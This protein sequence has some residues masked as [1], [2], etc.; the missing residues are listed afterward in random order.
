M[1][2][3]RHLATP[4]SEY[5]AL[6]AQ[7]PTLPPVRDV[8]VLRNMTKDIVVP[9]LNRIRGA[10]LPAETKY[11]VTDYEIAVDG[12]TISVRCTTPTK[13][14]VFPL[15]VWVHGGGFVTGTLEPD[16]Y[17]LRAL[18]VELGI[19]TVNV[20]YR[21]APE[22]RFPTPLN[23]CYA[24]LKWAADNAA[25][26]SASVTKGFI[27]GGQS[28]GGNLVAALAYRAREDPF[29]QGRALTGHLLQY[30]QVIHP[31]AVPARYKSELLSMEE[32]KDAPVLKRDDLLFFAQAYQAEPYN[33]ECSP[34]LYPS[35]AGL[36]PLYMQ[37]CGWD[38][39]RD[40]CLLYEK[41]L[42]EAGADTK[43]D[44]Y[45]G[46]PHIFAAMHPTLSQAVKHDRDMR[47]GIRWLLEKTAQS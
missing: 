15:M 39:V 8:Q 12:G 23:D 35:H 33:P 11:R 7:L 40:E 10:S 29:F 28:A 45:P 14:E 47:E 41:V 25:L 31:D 13:G 27:L 37:V 16:D 2:Q 4:D 42:R 44:I 19:V 18:S 32:L 9:T 3:N 38:P 1:A 24:A 6:L 26:L 34:L 5:A 30:P 36:P 22:F 46:V 20:E 21:L 43:I 17:L